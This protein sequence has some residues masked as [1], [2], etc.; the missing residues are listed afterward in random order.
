VV[1]ERFE[2]GANLRTPRYSKIELVRVNDLILM[3]MALA[4]RRVASQQGSVLWCFIL[5]HCRF[6]FV[7]QQSQFLDFRIKSI[8]SK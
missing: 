2:A 8:T 1:R 5:K 3:L 6:F 4:N 7:I